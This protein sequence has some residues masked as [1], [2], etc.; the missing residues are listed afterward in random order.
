M[1]LSDDTAMHDDTLPLRPA[2]AAWAE[3]L[4]WPPRAT[5]LMVI[6]VCGEPILVPCW[7]RRGG[8]GL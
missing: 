5:W 6:H 4:G 7:C 2:R 1:T 8:E 3:D